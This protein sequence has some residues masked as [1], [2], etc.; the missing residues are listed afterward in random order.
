[1]F[2]NQL[3]HLPLENEASHYL[4]LS[5]SP[6]LI[7]QFLGSFRAALSRM[8]PDIANTFPVERK[9]F[10]YPRQASVSLSTFVLVVVVS[11]QCFSVDALHCRMISAFVNLTKFLKKNWTFSSLYFIVFHKLNNFISKHDDEL[12]KIFNK[13]E[14]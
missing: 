11:L 10:M 5:R 14:C 3:A 2:C 12:N 1:M 13:R 4:C 6:V 9:P 8:V 7:L